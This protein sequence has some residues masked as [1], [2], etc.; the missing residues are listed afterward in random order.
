MN[1]VRS[2]LPQ[3][4]ETHVRVTH[5]SRP[6]LVYVGWAWSDDGEAAMSNHITNHACVRTYDRYGKEGQEQKKRAVSGNRPGS[7][8]TGR[9]VGWE[10]EGGQGGEGRGRERARQSWEHTAVR[11]SQISG[12][13]LP[14]NVRTVLKCKDCP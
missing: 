6:V 12:T 7:N 13:T 8:D 14:L 9:G 11:Y 1:E 5:E 3:P 2:E 4:D 10:E